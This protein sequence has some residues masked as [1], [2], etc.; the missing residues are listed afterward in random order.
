M[1][2]FL[3]FPGNG[4]V[5]SKDMREKSTLSKATNLCNAGWDARASSGTKI[6][7]GGM[8]NSTQVGLGTTQG[9]LVKR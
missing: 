1:I 8:R 2:T 7:N 4:E 3:V 6:N 5:E 9:L